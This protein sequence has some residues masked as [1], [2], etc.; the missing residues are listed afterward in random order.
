VFRASVA[1][2]ESLGATVVPV[3]IP[4]VDL[5]DAIGT[6]ILVVEAYSFHEPGFREQFDLYGRP[7]SS[8][9]VRGAL[10]SAAD[11]V[12]ATRA[13]GLFRR[14]MAEVMTSVD[15]IAMPTSPVPA[16]PFDDPTSVPYSRPSFTRLFN[17]T[18][19]P[20]ISVPC[21]FTPGGLPVGL[22]LSGRPFDDLGVLQLGHAYEQLHHWYRKMPPGF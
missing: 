19:Q 17:I 6:G 20:S 10:W 1:D 18:G 4:H 21:G 12:Q 9:V 11:Y 2:L 22:M 13:R 14:G 3:T 8:R 7:F 16:E 5:T 15:M